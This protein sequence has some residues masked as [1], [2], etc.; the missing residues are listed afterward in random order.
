MNSN[1]ERKHIA[2]LREY[3]SQDWM[4]ARRVPMPS[5]FRV[6]F[7]ECKN[8]DKHYSQAGQDLFVLSC[9]NGKSKGVYLDIGCGSPT[10]INNTYLLEDC[11]SWGGISI[12]ISPDP[13]DGEIL[14]WEQ[15]DS[16]LLKE[17][18]RYLD[19]DKITKIAS[20]NHFDYLSID[21]EPAAV[22]LECLKNIPFDK[23]SFSVITYEHDFYRG[24]GDYR[25]ESR[26]IIE[27][28]GYK[29]VCRNVKWNGLTFEDWY[30]NPNY[31]SRDTVHPLD[32]DDQEW[33]QILFTEDFFEQPPHT[34]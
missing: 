18:A 29:S 22:S 2:S 24:L 17:D 10:M 25:E 27:K 15:R 33:Q 32:S 30:Y 5:Q 7:N 19:F 12:D 34:T 13:W 3:K 9:L 26:E 4:G 8:I 28:N 20:S 21:L 23:V 14:S 6:P 31:I 16:L 11:F 1:N